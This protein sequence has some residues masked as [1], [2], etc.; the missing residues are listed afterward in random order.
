M[1]STDGMGAHRSIPSDGCDEANQLRDTSRQPNGVVEDWLGLE[2][3]CA[4][5][6][7]K[8]EHVTSVVGASLCAEVRENT[9]PR[10]DG[11]HYPPT[12]WA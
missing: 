8:S 12:H 1:Q 5:C 3:E 10:L 6:G 2:L 4:A 7:G 9:S 11:K